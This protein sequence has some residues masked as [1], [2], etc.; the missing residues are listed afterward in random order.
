MMKRPKITD[1]NGNNN[2]TLHRNP[3]HTTTQAALAVRANSPMTVI[4]MGTLSTPASFVSVSSY[5]PVSPRCAPGMRSVVHL[6]MVSVSRLASF[7]ELPFLDH[8]ARGMGAPEEEGN[9]R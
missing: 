4:L 6:R 3:H 5:S 7:S 9:Q 1:N 8:W 2:K